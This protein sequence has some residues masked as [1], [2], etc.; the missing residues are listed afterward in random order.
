M[1]KE[2]CMRNHT[3]FFLCGQCE[4]D[5]F[6]GKNLLICIIYDIIGSALMRAQVTKLR[7]MTRYNKKD[8][9]AHVGSNTTFGDKI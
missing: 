9:D 1:H 4:K 2:H 6:S 8:T 5:T 7:L 3:V